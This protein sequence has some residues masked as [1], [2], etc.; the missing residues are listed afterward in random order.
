MGALR[1]QKEPL[2]GQERI[3]ELT[4]K[5]PQVPRSIILKNDV[6]RE[7]TRTEDTSSTGTGNRSKRSSSKNPL[8][9]SGTTH[10]TER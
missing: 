10:R 3:E 7:G 8:N 5:L 6:L 1:I 2:Q 4:E 9:G